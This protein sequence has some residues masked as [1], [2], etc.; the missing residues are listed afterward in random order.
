[1][2][3]YAGV[4]FILPVLGLDELIVRRISLRMSTFIPDPMR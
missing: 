1:M 3:I 2:I 4:G